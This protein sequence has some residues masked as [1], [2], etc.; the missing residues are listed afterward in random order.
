MLN[1]FSKQFAVNSEVVTQED[2]NAILYSIAP[3]SYVDDEYA[4]F[5]QPDYGHMQAFLSKHWDNSF[6][7]YGSIKKDWPL[8]LDIACICASDMR[9]AC[10][11]EGMPYRLAFGVVRY[12]MN[13]KEPE[14]DEFD[15]PTG[16]TIHLRHAMNFVVTSNCQIKYYEPQGKTRWMDQPTDMKSL[17]NFDIS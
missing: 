9:K 4:H 17:D 1:I 5:L 14:L 15:K 12:T 7:V 11:R 16:N 8:C 13:A 6:F 3:D 10:L 2:L